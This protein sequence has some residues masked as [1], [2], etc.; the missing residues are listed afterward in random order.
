MGVN[1]EHNVKV[2][3]IEIAL[4]IFQPNRSVEH[5]PIRPRDS[6]QPLT[7]RKLIRVSWQLDNSAAFSSPLP[8]G[9]QHAKLSDHAFYRW[10]G[11]SFEF[12]V[13]LFR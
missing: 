2:L 3:A 13:Y 4:S 6:G 12:F 1:S 8:L 7:L 10:P 5:A 9:L 11:H